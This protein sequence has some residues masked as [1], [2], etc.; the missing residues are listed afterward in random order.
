MPKST[1]AS[2]PRTVRIAVLAIFLNVTTTPVHAAN[3]S[4][5]R[6]LS[7]FVLDR[8]EDGRRLIQGPSE[9]KPPRV[10]E[11]WSCVELYERRVDLLRET[12]HYKPPYW[13][14]PRNQAAIFIGTVWTP[15]FYF[16]GYSAV[17]AHLDDLN[18]NNPRTH[19]DALRRASARQR[20]FEK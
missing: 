19:L 12:N 9:I 5:E 13:D 20:C 18:G 16:L 6:R 2:W 8:Y 10:D 3:E 15:A 11:N 4:P 14:D 1:S 17:A 7:Q